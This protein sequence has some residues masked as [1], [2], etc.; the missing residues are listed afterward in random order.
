MISR[1]KTLSMMV[2]LFFL[3][4]CAATNYVHQQATDQDYS[5][6][7]FYSDIVQAVLLND[8]IVLK[9][10]R[11]AKPDHYGAAYHSHSILCFPASKLAN[12]IGLHLYPKDQ[13]RDLCPRD[14]D[15]LLASL[16]KL[17][18]LPSLKNGL[19]LPEL[20]TVIYGTG[21]DSM[22]TRCACEILSELGATPDKVF[23]FTKNLLY[24]A[25]NNGQWVKLSREKRDLFVSH[26]AA[27][28]V[29]EA[30]FQQE[31]QSS[32]F[33]VKQ[34]LFEKLPQ[35]NGYYFFVRLLNSQQY[36]YPYYLPSSLVPQSA[37]FAPITSLFFQNDKVREEVVKEE[38]NPFFY[39]LYPFSVVFDV[40][41]F[42]IQY[43]ITVYQ[44][45]KAT[46]PNK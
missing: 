21:N 45:N 29:T 32:R 14:I 1:V 36:I 22:T 17:K 11:E 38:G 2:Y 20:N 37:K 39:A 34:P 12:G 35:N 28:I 43:G 46:S 30:S 26:F 31:R 40:I 18:P 6:D 33:P 25:L 42:P 16:P 24:I 9:I 27:E 19:I 3:S 5:I 8:I 15:V 44:L 13:D 7:S 41:T 10:E 23:Y 4:G